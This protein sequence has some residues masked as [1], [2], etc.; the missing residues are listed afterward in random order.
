M[1]MF[2]ARHGFD[3]V[4]A[5]LL[6]V[7]LGACALTVFASADIAWAGTPK[8]WQTEQGK[9]CYYR[10]GEKLTGMQKIGKNYY[11]FNAKGVM[12]TG[13]AKTDGATY[14]LG[15]LGKMEAYAKG[16]TFYKPTGVKMKSYQVKEYKTLL[17]ARDKVTEITT[18]SMTKAQKLLAC[19]KWVQKGYYHTYR[20][21]RNYQGWAADFANDHFMRTW[22]GLRHGCC[23]SDAAAFGYLALAL[24]YKDVY[25]GIDSTKGTGGH[26]CTKIN[27]KYYDPL[28]AEAKS[29]SKYYGT[30]NG[31]YHFRSV[32]LLVPSASNNWNTSKYYGEKPATS[33][34]E[35]KASSKNG[36]AK[37]DGSYYYFQNGKK[38]KK[39]WKNW[40]D[41]RYYFKGDGTAAIGPTKVKGVWYV[42]GLNGKLKKGTKTRVVKVD[43]QK[44]Q[45]TKSGRAK[46]GQSDNKKYLFLENGRM[47]QGLSLYKRQ[48]YW[49]SDEGVYD[50]S[51][52]QAIR[53]AAKKDSNAAELLKL[54]GKP[55]SKK[56]TTGCNPVIDEEGNEVWGKDVTYTYRNCI[57]ELL[58]GENGITY[59]RGFWM[60]ES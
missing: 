15:D 10:D 58:K 35:V 36:L 47:A 55:L 11:Y 7:L 32:Q 25:V 49:L 29:F 1:N 56:S 45:V 27:G 48:V 43:G 21:F 24:G 16:G 50:E 33:E 44:Y 60:P 57:V 42:F 41:A 8:G 4:F 5:M 23:N 30:K 3:S 39:E 38:L 20:K 17:R 26:G 51:K 52:T 28:F 31:G 14:Y 34:E 54:I 6:A 9:K 12:K 53:A 37:L 40:R 22:K 18:K 13:T 59:F 19:F 2:D 46:A